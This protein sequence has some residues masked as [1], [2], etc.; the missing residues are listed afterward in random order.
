MTTIDGSPLTDLVNKVDTLRAANPIPGVAD[1]AHPIIP[2]HLPV[3][4]PATTTLLRGTTAIGYINTPAGAPAPTGAS[5]TLTSGTLWIQA[6]LLGAAF[7]SVSGFAG[8][9]FSGAT[10]KAIGSVTFSAGNIT[11]DTAATLALDLT[12]S[13]TP[14]TGAAG[15]PVGPD[16]LAAKLTPFPRATERVNRRWGPP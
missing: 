15:D 16:F 3:E 2:I 11:L 4:L 12:S 6:S 8:V 10:L 9:P 7:S 14:A 13:V 5:V 1:I